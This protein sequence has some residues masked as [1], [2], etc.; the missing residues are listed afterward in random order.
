MI[1]TL[2]RW[3]G[4]IAAI[5]LI[6]LSLSGAALSVFPTVEALGAPRAT[7]GQTVADLARVIQA[8]YPGVEQIRRAPSGKITAWWFDGNAPGSATVAPATG[9][10]VATADPSPVQQ[11]LITL[12]RSL[13]LDDTGRLVMAG[14]AAAMLLLAASGTVLALRRVGGVR[15]WFASQRGP[16]GPRLHTVLA[17]ISLPFLIL[18][19]VTA[20]W[21]AASTFD[22]LP[23]DEAN[24][25]FPRATSGQTGI[26]PADIA[27]LRAIPVSDLRDITFPAAG[28]AGDVYTLTTAT[29]T[30]YL[31]QGTGEVLNW[32]EPGLWT[33]AWEWVY[34]LHTG[35]GAA[36]WGLILG[37]MV[38]TV[39]VL[40]VTG[41][42]TWAKARAARPKL[43]G[44]VSA[45]RAQTVILVASE[46]G[47]TWGFAAT[48]ARALQANGTSVHLAELAQFAPQTYATARE[49]IVMAATWGDGAAPASAGGALR[50]IAQAT[51]TV[52][53][54]VLGFGDSNFPAFCGF[55][56]EIAATLRAAGW[57]M[58]VPFAQIDRQSPQEFARW[59]RDL[60]AALARPLALNH[61]VVAPQTVPL[62]LISRRDY[63]EAVQAPGAI[64]RFA[65]PQTGLWQRIS[66]RGF[67][68]FEAG[69]L[70]GILPE[71]LPEVLDKGA[72][73]GAQVPRFYSLASGRL[74]G[75]IEIA[76]RK[77]PG[78]LCSSQ[79]IALQP[80]DTVRGFLRPNPDFHPDTRKTPLILIGAG[81]GI[82]PLI[83]FI[84]S[85]GSRRP[86]HLWFGARHPETDFFYGET[87]QD[88]AG[89]GRLTR[90]QTA[91][92]R[93]DHRRYV[94][95]ALRQD[96][97]LLRDLIARGAK[98]FVCGGRDMALGVREA[99]TEAL[100][101]IGITAAALKSEGRYAEDVY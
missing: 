98:V 51:P 66:G 13:F 101:P 75:F 27:A 25:A 34:L 45:G 24:P 69:D 3:P 78:G 29:G 89:E 20:L 58:I 82:A 50:R 83:G 5:L 46:G 47:T 44:M 48:L 14:A 9:N 57:S 88:W 96:A 61:Q 35:Q 7:G 32:A 33:R 73:I 62:T 80:G 28:D 11:W 63:G 43:R 1:R 86:V 10:A 79:L 41:G 54:A 23:V 90:L 21:M 36:L 60:G 22:L 8:E 76:I 85:Q 95:D 91:F 31:D 37:A 77:H 26:A 72:R 4:L 99:L 16:L 59:G 68:G 71:V 30:G 81:T 17:R 74:D 19:G 65:L 100:A 42:V 2:H 84:R 12:H 15:H 87:L 70:L 6:V 97:D 18:T 56:N 52:P 38:L 49:I 92:S 94:Q 40:A 39:P 93:G 53:I 64:L 67:G 55:A